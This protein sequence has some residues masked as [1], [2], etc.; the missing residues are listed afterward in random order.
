MINKTYQVGGWSKAHNTASGHSIVA[1]TLTRK[2][3][4]WDTYSA[5]CECG[6][7]STRLTYGITTGSRR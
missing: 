5:Q 3:M 4:G 2:G 6:A 7:E 1:M